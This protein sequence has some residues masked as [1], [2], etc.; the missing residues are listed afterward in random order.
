M[1]SMTRSPL[2]PAPAAESDHDWI[3]ALRGSGPDHDGAVRLLH[4]TVSRATRHQVRSMP[5]V[6]SQLGTARAE[7]I[8]TAAADEATAAVLHNLDRFE[9]RSRFS[10]WVYKFGILHAASEA[11]RMLWR[12]RPVDLSEQPE[13]IPADPH[14][15]EALAEA[16]DLAGAVTA[17]MDVVLTPRQKRIAI[18]LIVEEVPIDVLAERMST[19]RNALYKALHDIRVKLRSELLGL[20]YLPDSGRR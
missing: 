1:G 17:A 9:G 12:D 15:T 3:R 20:G 11:R 10:T 19:N 8:I 13:S 6:W 5:Q 4:E 18:A 2:R 14:S 7:E 16:R